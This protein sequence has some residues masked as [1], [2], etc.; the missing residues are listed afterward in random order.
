MRYSQWAQALHLS[1][2]IF[3]LFSI[4]LF[5]CVPIQAQDG[6]VEKNK[7]MDWF[8]S[9]E[10]IE[11]IAYLLPLAAED[12]SNLQ[13]LGYLGY[14]YYMNDDKQIAE[15]Y[16]QQIYRIDSN[17][18]SANQYLAEIN[19][20]SN[21]EKALG[22]AAH[23]IRVQ[24]NKAGYYRKLA[25]LLRKINQKDSALVYYEYAYQISP[26][27]FRNATG[28]VELLIDQKN[29]SRADSILAWG[30][31]RDSLSV[32]FLR[33]SIRSA[34]ESK[35][36][37]RALDPGEKLIRLQENLSS[38]LSQLVYSYFNLK[39]YPD[40]IRVCEYMIANSMYSESVYYYEAK[41]WAMLKD[42]TKSND[43]LQ[44][45][46]ALA[47]SKTAELYYYTLGD[48]HEQMKQFK[49]AITQ[50]DT[51]YYL[52]K[53]PIM[54]YNCGRISE[55][56]MHK[57][58]LTQQYYAKYLATGRPTTPGE[59]KAYDYVR[60]NWGKKRLKPTLSK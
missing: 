6:K 43:L 40:C 2:K 9:Q 52:F 30:L 35:Q 45:C 58:N 29:F 8:Q 28:L 20:S 38:A 56:Y 23:L 36:Y 37:T 39:K 7:V 54:L 1:K 12:S 17:S 53:N 27:D 19:S 14:A 34:Y 55:A 5:S 22:F 3:L 10:Y 31:D 13:V 60:T 18:V 59:R 47:I 46:L 15:Q 42:F 57:P 48:N 51:A 11:A 41:S 33:L 16:Y 44:L 50:Y 25:E 24:P 49:N 21:P 26:A 32:P 4:R